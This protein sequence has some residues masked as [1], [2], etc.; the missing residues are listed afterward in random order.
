[1]KGGKDNISIQNNL[2]ESVLVQ[3][4]SEG[5]PVKSIRVDSKKERNIKLLSGKNY[6]ILGISP[7]TRKFQLN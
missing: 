3:L 7:P 6:S 2:S 1:M 5:R 4:W